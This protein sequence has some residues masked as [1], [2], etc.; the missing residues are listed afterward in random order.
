MRRIAQRQRV[1]R[2]GK[3]DI[4]LQPHQFAAEPG[5]L[6]R[7]RQRFAQ[8]GFFYRSDVGDHAFDI[9]EFGDQFRRGLRPDAA[10]PRD[11][12]RTVPHQGQHIAD[13]FG[14]HAEFLD[15]FG[16]VDALVL[17]RVE[18]VD[19]RLDQLH[20]ILVGRHDGDIEPR[21]QRRQRIA[22][23]DVV[24]LETLLLDAWHRKRPHRIADQGELRHQV[25]G[26]RRPMRLVMFVHVVAKRVRP[27]I[28]DDREVR[29][30][31]GLVEFGDQLPDHRGEAID[32]PHRR[33]LRIVQR[34]QPVI[35]AK[36]IAGAI[37]EIEMLLGHVPP[38]INP[39]A[40]KRN[41]H[42]ETSSA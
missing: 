11:I 27:G 8:L 40:F 24:G 5:V 35:G 39:I 26:R 7:R 22:G 1:Q 16:A 13:L 21:R 3:R 18:Q 38:V 19:P 23:D 2:F 10:H 4:V 9:A 12:V 29:R 32:R 36:D 37:D 33:P 30:R 17:H 42:A 28:E 6:H 15:D 31:L 25:L 41:R 34:R 20:Q 14:R